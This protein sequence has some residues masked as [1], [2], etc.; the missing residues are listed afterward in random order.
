MIATLHIMRRWP[1]LDV[2]PRVSRPLP[3]VES[4]SPARQRP[5]D[6]L[7][8]LDLTQFAAGPY[9]L[10]FL[11]D[12]GARVIKIE[13]PGAGDPYR[14][15]G[16]RLRGGQ[17]GEGTYFMRFNRNRE[18][19]A[20]D[21][22]QP[23][24]R[25]ALEALIAAA[26]V[27]AENFRPG[28]ME[29]LGLGWDRLRELN[30]RLVYATITGYGHTDL[31]P[32]PL[33]GWPAFAITAEAMGGMMDVIGEADCEPHGSGVS[34]GDLV[35]GVEAALGIMFAL[36]QRARTG[37]G[38]RVDV[39]MADAMAALNERAI[40]SYNLTS[41]VPRRG[42]ERQIAPFGPFATSDGHVAI[43]VIGP[44]VW[45]RLCIA[46]GR[47]ELADDPDLATGAGRARH[48]DDRVR[49]AILA[50]LAGRTKQE[51]AAALCEAGVPAAP[52][53][54]ARDVSESE[55]F[56]SRRM[57]LEFEYPGAGSVRAVGSPIKLGDDPDPP[58][59][60]PPLLGEHTDAVLADVAGLDA[61]AIAELR[62]EGGVG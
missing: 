40:F 8:V 62:R 54:T 24:G 61:D 33:S 42:A 2:R 14:H 6:D 28:T 56:R 26:D 7:V 30:P 37:R 48:L 29:R 13:L 45:R 20:L 19:V 53:M 12:A 22:R 21:L 3:D 41:E 59:A 44:A 60:R 9:G 17:P 23:G 31:M 57:L 50:W 52:V 38:Q 47:P 43:G 1:A 25:R 16:P 18:S 4:P 5:L 10:Q 35:A 39:A 51:A 27:L 49:P 32:S 34:A 36:H 11:A 46:I 58:V 15:E 55:H